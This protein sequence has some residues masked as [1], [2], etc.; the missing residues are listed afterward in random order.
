MAKKSE[1]VALVKLSAFGDFEVRFGKV[2]KVQKLAIAKTADGWKLAD[3]EKD[4]PEGVLY[5]GKD[6]QTFIQDISRYPE[7]VKAILFWHGT[8]QKTGDEYADMDHVE[9]CMEAVREMDERLAEGKFYADR[10][11][12]AGVSVL[13]R[14]IMKVYGMDEAAVRE[15]LKPLS[16]KEKQA[17]RVSAELKAAV[18]EIERERG[19]GVDTGA[20]L[21]KIKPQVV[22]LN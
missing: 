6:G 2:D 7:N 10:Q 13:M 21:G 9:D 15:F 5:V 14:A 20:L 18:E 19:K 11:G 17:L 3:L 4:V 16:V 12:F 1:P 8:K 22:E